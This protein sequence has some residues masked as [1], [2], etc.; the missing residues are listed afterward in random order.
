MRFAWLVDVRARLAG[1]PSAAC[2]LVRAPLSRFPGCCRACGQPA[3]QELV[4]SRHCHDTEHRSFGNPS[5]RRADDE[6]RV[7]CGADDQPG[8]VV[9]AGAVARMRER[10]PLIERDAFDASI[11]NLAAY[12]ALR[13]YDLR[14]L[15]V[16]LLGA[17]LTSLGR[18]EGR[19]TPNLDAV[20]WADDRLFGR[21]T[22]ERVAF[23][24]FFAG[25]A[26]LV[27]ETDAVFGP[28]SS[29]RCSSICSRPTLT[30]VASIAP[31]MIQKPGRGWRRMRGLGRLEPDDRCG[32]SWTSPARRSVPARSRRRSA[33]RAC[34]RATRCCCAGRTRLRRLDSRP[35]SA[36][37]SPVR[38]WRSWHSCGPVI[39]SSSRMAS[40][41]PSSRRRMSAVPSCEWLA[42][43][44]R[45]GSRS[46]R[47]G[48]AF[49]IPRSPSAP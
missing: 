9:S 16:D 38:R 12:L 31:T 25:Q 5:R 13:R 40:W 20:I 28:R 48:S 44:P 29:P 17:G 2:R 47:N 22:A 6:R 23:E 14:L 39:G 46:R 30:S 15:Q 41:Q 37:P 4:R 26:S 18:L 33:S 8:R 27:R 32:F 7:A 43:V 3:D 35:R 1:V 42:S 24:R 34:R 21:N 19:V 36:S 11:A 10:A 49:P 45:A